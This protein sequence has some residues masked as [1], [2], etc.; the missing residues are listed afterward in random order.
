MNGG[1]VAR[2]SGRRGALDANV[3]RAG[4]TF[5]LVET[6]SD[7]LLR[8]SRASLQA[9]APL[10]SPRWPDSL[11]EACD[12]PGERA[13]R[14]A[15]IRAAAAGTVCPNSEYA[16]S[17]SSNGLRCNRRKTVDPARDSHNRI[18]GTGASAG[19]IFESINRR[20][21]RAQR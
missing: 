15:A 21:Q 14:D 12:R 4:D 8:E 3:C 7:A 1:I 20:S 19:G 5:F 11:T 16:F 2:G 10:F 13:S 18:E 9:R 6:V 17:A